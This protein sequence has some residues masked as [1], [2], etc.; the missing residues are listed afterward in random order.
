MRLHKRVAPPAHPPT[1]HPPTFPSFIRRTTRTLYNK[2]GVS[3]EAGE[4]G[5]DQPPDFLF[6][7][8]TVQNGGKLLGAP[9]PLPQPYL[10]PTTVMKAPV[11]FSESIGGQRRPLAIIP[12]IRRLGQ[13]DND[14]RL[15]RSY[16]R[17]RARAH[18]HT[19]VHTR[20][21]EHTHICMHAR[22]HTHTQTHTHYAYL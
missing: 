6:D 21:R 22:A 2:S 10:M 8:P 7:H 19:H 1:R 18:T 17:T 14:Q 3:P 13:D 4:R 11:R 9:C 15:G 20:V 12:W 16:G 5:P